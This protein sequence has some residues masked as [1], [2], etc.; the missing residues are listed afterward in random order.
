MK[1][2]PSSRSQKPVSDIETQP[3]IDR[4]SL[5]KL[6][7]GAAGLIG[8]HPL[9][10]ALKAAPPSS[11]TSRP[12][13]QGGDERHVLI[14][15]A[16]LAGLS[17]AYELKKAGY[18]STILEARAR[19]GGRCWTVRNGS[20]IVEAGEES[21]R[22]NF[23][24]NLYF[25]AGPDRIP[26]RHKAILDYCREFGLSLRAFVQLNTDAYYYHENSGPLSNQPVRIRQAWIDLR[27]YTFSLLARAIQEG[28]VDESFD[29]VER[30]LLLTFLQN[31]GNLS[32]SYDY[33]GSTK[34]GFEVEP[35]AWGQSGSATDPLP[36]DALLESNFWRHPPFASDSEDM[37]VHLQPRDG[38]DAI[39]R[40]FTKELANDIRF[41]AEVKE[42]RH[43]NSKIEVVYS[44]GSQMQ[45][46]SGDYCICTI[47]LPVLAGIDTNF[48]QRTV[49]AMRNIPYLPFVKVGLEFNRRF[50]EED[51]HIYAGGTF[52]NLN[53]GQIW[54]PAS[55]LLGTHGLVQGAYQWGE[56]AVEL[57]DLKPEAR[58]A[59]ALRQGSKIHPQYHDTFENGVSIAWHK[60]PY[61]MGA[62]AEYDENARQQLYPHLFDFDER[63]Y[64][65]GDHMSYLS[66]WM[67][68]AVLS[69]HHAIE[70]IDTHAK[71]NS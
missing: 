21:Q 15:G 11:Y 41:G 66:G 39:V 23:A 16:G 5:L 13:L 4:R 30:K 49:E 63:L 64:L 32:S 10:R 56:A 40:A 12:R 70:A 34:A 17:A 27:G 69:A 9:A 20:S 28:R 42:I 22:A 57:G 44:D 50:W 68:G 47:P 25:D 45:R 24:P 31:N 62:W 6:F 52:T 8:T 54:Y 35:G 14:L 48:P 53:I 29:A 51:E 61:S 33:T 3:T 43:E 55:G 60:E 65:A 36:F 38:M 71:E 1:R 37:W 59:E 67:E 18:R 26:L 46:I 2:C 19:A 7:G 58:I